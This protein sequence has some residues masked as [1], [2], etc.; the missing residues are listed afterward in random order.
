MILKKAIKVGTPQIHIATYTLLEYQVA[1]YGIFVERLLNRFWS[2][3]KDNIEVESKVLSNIMQ[4]F[5]KWMIETD[6]EDEEQNVGKRILDSYHI[7]HKTYRNLLTLVRG[8]VGYVRAVLDISKD[9]TYIPA[10][11][12]TNHFT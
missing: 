2:I 11:H 6:I 9:D 5:S 4:Y 1:V 10:L 12:K 8:F 3:T 7:S